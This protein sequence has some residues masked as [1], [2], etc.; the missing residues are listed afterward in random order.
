MCV[1]TFP[2]L[3]EVCAVRPELRLLSPRAVSSLLS[4]VW[5]HHLQERVLEKPPFC[6]IWGPV[7][8]DA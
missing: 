1:P 8:Q 5:L 4:A 3:A 6:A 7:L 2:Q